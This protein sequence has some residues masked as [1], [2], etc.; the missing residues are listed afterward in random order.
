MDAD[1]ACLVVLMPGSGP[2]SDSSFTRAVGAQ[3]FPG[4]ADAS[5]SLDTSGYLCES[6]TFC[7]AGSYCPVGTGLTVRRRINLWLIA[8]R[9]LAPW[10]TRQL[11]GVWGCG[12]SAK[13]VLSP[14]PCRRDAVDCV[15]IGL[16]RFLVAEARGA[17]R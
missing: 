14:T 13:R 6:E 10:V 1:G 8:A 7:P 4:L 3:F 12:H 2:D 9:A 11:L 16:V 15:W 17:T 5:D